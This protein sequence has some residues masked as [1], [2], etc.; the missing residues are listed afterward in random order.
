L[1]SDIDCSATSGWNG[2]AG[3][4]P[5]GSTGFT[6]NLDGAGHVVNHLFINSSSNYQG[7]IGQQT[8]GSIHDIGIVN[9]NISGS[10]YYVVA[11]VERNP[12]ARSQTAMP[13]GNVFGI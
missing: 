11:L 13:T 3:F 9:V 12:V 5:I 8:S 1:A 7:L 4:A 6:G 2:G 10:N